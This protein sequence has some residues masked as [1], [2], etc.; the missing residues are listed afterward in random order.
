MGPRYTRETLRTAARSTTNLDEALCLLGRTPTPARR[1]YLRQKLTEWGIDTA[2]FTSGRVRHT[3]ERLR[4]A[5]AA[6]TS[7]KDVLRHL[8]ISPVGG[9]HAHIN[10]RIAALGIDTAHFA[11][12]PRRSKK[13]GEL[14]R[15]GLPE[16]GRTPGARLLR[17]L[18]LGGVP[19]SCAMCATGATWNGRPLRLQ[20]DHINGDWWDN[21][22]SNLRL[23]CPNCHA[24]TDTY[25]GRKRGPGT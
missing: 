4:A 18:L 19:E 16:Q 24:V 13:P 14:L 3:E 8:G 1:G 25:R 22:A 23:L 20:V 12:R 6:S 17:E 5:V 11:Q 2:H 7:V 21:R 9:N 10:R 15:L